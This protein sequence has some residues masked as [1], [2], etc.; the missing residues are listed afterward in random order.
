MS[1]APEIPRCAGGL[2]RRPVRRRRD[3]RGVAVPAPRLFSD[4]A[5]LGGSSLFP[6]A[7]RTV[8][9]AGGRAEC[10]RSSLLDS[11]RGAH[12]A[13]PGFSGRGA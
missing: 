3:W 8:G 1:V 12:L 2:T 11:G 4:H 6:V 7:A 9:G 5:R 13:A 10:P